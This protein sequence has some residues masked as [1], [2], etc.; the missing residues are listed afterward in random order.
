VLSIQIEILVEEIIII[1]YAATTSKHYIIK[2]LYK[3]WTLVFGVYSTIL[4]TR[5]RLSRKWT[6]YRARESNI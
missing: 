1:I 3:L 2:E 4:I 6:F 5:K